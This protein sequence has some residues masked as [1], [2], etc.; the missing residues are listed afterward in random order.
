[1]SAAIITEDLLSRLAKRYGKGRQIS[2]GQVYAFGSALSCS[3][4]Y[5]KLLGGQKYFF[6]VPSAMLGD[7]TEFPK[8]RFGEFA[9]F[10]CGSVDNVL[11]IPRVIILQ[12]LE[13]VPTRRVDIFHEA[14]SF[15]LQTTKHPKLNVTEFLNAFPSSEEPTSPPEDL[16]G[17]A[18]EATRIH[19]KI[20]W[21]N[22]MKLTTRTR[23]WVG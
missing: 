19:V 7:A 14:G 3:L 16:V 5:S 20:Q 2:K 13:G 12:M 18:D 11:V 1:M 4:N 6:A 23:S 22:G 17:R 9:L 10:V 8:T 15:I 21:S